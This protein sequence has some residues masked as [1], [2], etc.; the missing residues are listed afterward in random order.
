MAHADVSSWREFLEAREPGRAVYEVPTIP[1][2]AFRWWASWI[3]NCMR[4]GVPEASWPRI[5]TLYGDGP[6]VQD[7]LGHNDFAGAVVVLLDAGGVVRWFGHGG[8][9]P[10]MGGGLRDRLHRLADQPPD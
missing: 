8:F 3:D 4:K 2:I 10:E 5:V 6:P 9:T 1:A 7:L